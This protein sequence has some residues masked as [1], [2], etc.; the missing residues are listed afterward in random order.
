MKNKLFK[1][2]I[3]YSVGEIGCK[4][5]LFFLVP[6]YT[7]VLST[8]DYGKLDLINT[9]I[10]MLVPITC[11]Q[12]SDGILRFTINKS[13][14][15]TKKVINTTL[16]FLLISSVVSS[17]I[18]IIILNLF[19]DINKYLVISMIISESFLLIFRQIL[20]G[21]NKI[22]LYSVINIINTLVI[23]IL[24]II[25]IVNLGFGYI[26]S[27]ISSIISSII[28][29]F[30]IIIRE[31][32]YFRFCLKEFDF[33]ILKKMLAYSLPLLPVGLNWWIMSSSDRLIMGYYLGMNEV[34]I[35]GVANKFS[36]IFY[37]INSI[38]FKSWQTY[39]ISEK[40]S[41]N[42]VD[43]CSI[44]FNNI[45]FI[46]ISL[47][48]FTNIMIEPILMLLL[49]VEFVSAWKYVSILCLGVMFWMLSSL[50]STVFMVYKENKVLLKT[51]ILGAILNIILNIVFMKIIGIYAAALSTVISFYTLMVLRI[52]GL[53][54]YGHFEINKINFYL[55]ILF[56]TIVIFTNYLS[57]NIRILI[58]I[59]ILLIFL[60]INVK[61]LKN[62][63]KQK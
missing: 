9:I 2:T 21:I 41:E 42:L 54:K 40:D 17:S 37:L 4:I 56:V 1:D 49:G 19:T 43:K 27:I 61:Y 59:F 48:L 25:F 51:S 18:L 47:I 35:Y 10:A 38:F 28:C 46:E 29:I 60:L 7:R 5:I 63:F 39:I 32:T 58:Q 20:R 55:G 36:S 57:S 16:I 45:F 6:F 52:R 3:I 8:S 31:P 33:I 50:V 13:K 24:N 14:D 23:A 34:G 12:L 53:K 44:A 30:I 22:K 15:Y 11:F 26:G 62:I